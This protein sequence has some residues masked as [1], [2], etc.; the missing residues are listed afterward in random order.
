MATLAVTGCSY[1]DYT[2]VDKVYGEYAAEQLGYNYLHLARG[3][4]SNHRGLLKVTKAVVE[5]K[6]VAGDILVFQY[7]DPHRKIL[8]S[9]EPE[10]EYAREQIPGKPEKWETIHGD[11][12]STDY[13]TESWTWQGEDFVGKTN[14]RIHKLLQYGAINTQF[15]TE[16]MAL[17]QAL[18]ES[19]CEVHDIRLIPL[20]TRYILYE[21]GRDPSLPESIHGNFRQRLGAKAA[22]RC[23]NEKDIINIGNLDDQSEDDLGYGNKKDTPPEEGYYDSSH[24]SETGHKKLGLYIAKHAKSHKLLI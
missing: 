11:G 10:G 2:G 4:G 14:G 3:A 15:E 23:I 17:H 18:L 5:K 21:G 8:P 6:L 7:T 16:Q 24:L 19:L 12:W 1:S 20:L 22:N 13:K 9:I